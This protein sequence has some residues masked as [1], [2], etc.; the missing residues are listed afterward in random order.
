M[1]KISWFLGF[2]LLVPFYLVF[3][4]VPVVYDTN[5]MADT[6][7]S[8]DIGWRILQGADPVLDF[9]HHYAGLF[10][11]YIALGFSLFGPTLKALDYASLLMAGTA[12][13]LGGVICYRRTGLWSYLLFA[14]FTS[15]CMLMRAPMEIIPAIT[16]PMSAHSFVYNRFAMSLGLAAFFYCFLAT[17]NKILEAIAGA[18][19]GAIIVML[20]LLK[21]SFGVILPAVLLVLLIQ[22][23]IWSGIWVAVGVVMAMGLLDPGFSKFIGSSRYAAASVGDRLTPTGLI[24]KTLGLL[25]NQ[26]T[27]LVLAIA[28]L[29]LTLTT[30]GVA[31]VPVLITTLALGAGAFG[32]A[33]TMGGMGSIGHQFLVL[34]TALSLCLAEVVRQAGAGPRHPVRIMALVLMAAFAGPHLLN[35]LGTGVIALNNQSRVLFPAGPLAGYYAEARPGKDLYR[36]IS[37]PNAPDRLAQLTRAATIRR[38]EGAP[39]DT[40]IEYIMLADGFHQLAQMPGAAE[41]GIAADTRFSFSFALG[42]PP[43]LAY[44]PWQWDTS[45]EFQDPE[46][47]RADLDIAMIARFAEAESPLR[48][49]TKEHFKLCRRSALWDIYLRD[50]LDRTSCN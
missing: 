43:V 19:T 7:F 40:G 36:V 50:G 10:G 26:P 41:Y 48:R 23:R 22:G 11:E 46:T 13:I 6:L 14:I 37:K 9:G 34:V 38:A 8:A 39:L 4:V 3:A 31:W 24:W 30:A 20:M 45:P 35:T 49:I 47:L 21:T 15:A 33:L 42:A 17:P 16:K 27:V 44:P 25:S 29:I 2:G 18:V 28:S 12:L 1:Q 32:M 5:H